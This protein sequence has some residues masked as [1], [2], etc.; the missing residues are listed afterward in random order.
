[1]QMQFLRNRNLYSTKV[2]LQSFSRTNVVYHVV[3]VVVFLIRHNVVLTTVVQTMVHVNLT[4]ITTQDVTF[5]VLTI[6]SGDSV[7]KFRRTTV[8]HTKVHTTVVL[9]EVALA[10][11]TVAE[12]VVST[13]GTHH[14]CLL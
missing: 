6:T 11:A 7:Q 8:V 14:P 3:E 4:Q 2:L 1:M 12:V 13:V 10:N 5:A 9:T